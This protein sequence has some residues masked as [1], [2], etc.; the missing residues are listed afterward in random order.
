MSQALTAYPTIIPATKMITV[1]MRRI[2]TSLEWHCWFRSPK[3]GG[4]DDQYPCKATIVHDTPSSAGSQSESEL[5][6]RLFPPAPPSTTVPRP[7]PDWADVHR[8]MKARKKTKVT[9]QLLWMEYKQDRPD[10]LQY[11]QF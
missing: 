6:A 7:L 10:G 2:L 5:E 1:R 4:E 9:L 3:G 11:S 8:E